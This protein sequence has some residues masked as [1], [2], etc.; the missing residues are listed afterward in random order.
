MDYT[1]IKTN[2]RW[3]Y[4]LRD[5]AGMYAGNALTMEQLQRFAL[6]EGAKLRFEPEIERGRTA[7]AI[8]GLGSRLLLSARLRSRD[9]RL[10]PGVAVS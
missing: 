1:V 4:E 3:G 5:A 7:R 10:V 8:L 9:R 6:A 2:D